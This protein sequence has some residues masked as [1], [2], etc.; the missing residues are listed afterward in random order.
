MRLV[1]TALRV[2]GGG[3]VTVLLLLA[4]AFAVL[5]TGPGKNWLAR[6]LANAMASAGE[7]V[8]IT[9]ISGVVPFDITIARIEIMDDQ[10][11]RALLEGAALVIAP[12]DLLRGTLTIQR[13][14]AQRVRLERPSRSSSGSTDVESLLHPPLAL[15]LDELRID[16]LALAAS[17]ALLANRAT[18][19]LD[20]H[21]IDGTPGE[22]RLHA[23]LAG[24][25]PQLELS[26]AASEPSGR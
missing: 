19:D 18:A 2:A 24:T 4:L 26:A 8:A 11:P 13:L 25:P 7:R 1:R 6:A 22:V 10:G 16:R 23:A 12:G 21:R 3:L 9:D 20:L 14:T 5:Q 17:A 15:R